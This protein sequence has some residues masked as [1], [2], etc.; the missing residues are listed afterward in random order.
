ME[1]KR[2]AFEELLTWKNQGLRKPLLIRGAR[3]VGKTTLVRK[4]SKEF[5]N[6]VELNLE[7]EKDKV[8]FKKSDDVKI[9][10]NAIF[11][12]YGIKYEPG[13]TL[14]FIDEI[15]EMPKA[16]QMLRFLY[17]EMPDLHVIAA[18]S[19]LEFA[20]KNVPSFPVGR[21]SYLN[22]YP[23]SFKEFINTVNPQAALVFNQ[24][25][26]PAFAQTVL[27][28]L[29]HEYAVLGG[30]PEVLSA[31]L[32]HRNM[33]LLNEKY[34]SLWLSYKNDAEKYARSDTERK[35]LRHVIE[36]APRESD[37]VSFA[38]FGQSAY[39]SREV[40]EAL[41]ALDMARLIYLIYPVTSYE[42]PLIPNLR[43]KPRLQFVDTGMLLN[44]LQFQGEMLGVN[45]LNDFYRGKFI[46]HLACQELM[47][48]SHDL[49]YRPYFWVKENK[50]SNAEIDIVLQYGSF[51]IPVEV[52]SGKAGT[53]RSLHQF[54][55]S[56]PHPYAIRLYAGNF[57]VEKLKTPLGKSF[58]LM[59]LPYFLA[60]KLSEYIKYF[61]NNYN[62]MA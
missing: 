13:N 32:D 21:V 26:L 14:L 57:S 54:M 59:N 51:V 58:Y 2:E 49:F 38:G 50:D 6:Y 8:F 18:G 35:V 16:I 25:P 48:A 7:K 56:A 31:Y 34:K 11:L 5:K 41:R 42:A 3:Q 33:S 28:N 30:M 4:F 37:R 60:S 22:I 45:D 62:K 61:V 9:I 24:V 46:H 19:L 1:I 52:K 27:M 12:S 47:A 44:I 40:G 29:F 23:V 55:Q 53:L 20:L 39:R 17:E 15:Q 43:K 36:T 10:I